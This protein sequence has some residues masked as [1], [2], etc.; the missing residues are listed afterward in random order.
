MIMK[1]LRMLISLF[2]L[3]LVIGQLPVIKVS[4]SSM[5]GIPAKYTSEITYLV[6]KSVVK[7]YPDG[8]F[9]GTDEVTREQAATMVG[10]ALGLNGQVRKSA[11]PDVNERSYASGYIQSAVEAGIIK[12]YPDGTYKP[13]SMMTRGEM[14]Y[15]ISHALDLEDTSD[16]S[17][18]DVN[19]KSPVYQSVNLLTTAGISEGT[20]GGYFLPGKTIT[21]TEFSLFVA[22]GL[23]SDFKVS[24]EEDLEVLSEKVVDADFLN[25]RQGPGTQYETV[26]RLMTG[27]TVSVYKK[28]GDWRFIHSGNLKGYVHSYYLLDK[29]QGNWTI[30][31]DPG[32][33]G[34]DPGASANGLVEKELVL[35]VSL[36]A[37]E[38]MENTGVDVVMTRQTDWYPSLDGRVALATKND[39]D[40]F[41]SIHANAFASSA[42][43]VETF[44]YAAGLSNREYAS[45]KL[46]TFINNR[47]YKEMDMSNRGVKNVGYRVV[48]HNPLPAV[49]TEIG[50]LTNETDA[51][52]LKTDHYREAAARAIAMGVVDYYNWKE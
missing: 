41:V 32:H 31:L 47:L 12:G 14:A 9:H 19:Q 27:E 43:G 52:K 26:G 29:P 45:V 28:E 30:A 17:Y 25:V 15:L 44:Y 16:I 49:L 42:T 35:D 48:K 6:G 18:K 1:V 21:R 8:H 46:A 10:R 22:R 4:A 20:P 13:K 11:F 38:Y 24:Q 37:S 3:S 5:E 39:A 33:G 2:L 50:F 36:K 51:S 23:N 34:R 40:A 7:G